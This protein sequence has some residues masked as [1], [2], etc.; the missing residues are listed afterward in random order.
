MDILG[1]CK[2]G[3]RK[4]GSHLVL[5]MGLDNNDHNIYRAFNTYFSKRYNQTNQID[6]TD[7][8]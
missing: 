4:G 3:A 7:W 6:K 5:T 8:F 2:V 1:S